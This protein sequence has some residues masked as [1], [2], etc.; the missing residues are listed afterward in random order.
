MLKTLEV[1]YDEYHSGYM[2]IH[3]ISADCVH[4]GDG[5][6][7]DLLPP[8]AQCLPIGVLVVVK[9][10]VLRR[11]LEDLGFSSRP[12]KG[13]HEVWTCPGYGRNVV[14]YGADGED[15]KP[16]QVAKVHRF[17]RDSRLSVRGITS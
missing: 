16:Y 8:I 2:A 9:L 6:L 5:L 10:S 17:H 15:A 14:L 11:E 13:S 1:L 7:Y 3:N 12:G 4:R